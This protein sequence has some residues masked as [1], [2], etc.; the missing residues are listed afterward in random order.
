MP[1]L[2]QLEAEAHAIELL[3]DL[4]N[5]LERLV[6]AELRDGLQYLHEALAL[7]HEADG[8]AI[9]LH[10]ARQGEEQALQGNL[11]LGRVEGVLA[12]EALAIN[13]G[14]EGLVFL[15]GEL[16]VAALDAHLVIVLLEL[17]LHALG[18]H[19]PT[20]LGQGIVAGEGAAWLALLPRAIEVGLG[21]LIKSKHIA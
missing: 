14:G 8:V 13:L 15:E 21:E 20:R 19:C 11:A 3:A 17:G 16:R 9:A 5:G 12:A 6:A 7:Y 4:A 2:R 1:L 10:I 18:C